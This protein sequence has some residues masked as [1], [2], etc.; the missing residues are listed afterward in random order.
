MVFMHV[1]VFIPEGMS[2]D[3]EGEWGAQGR[4]P[5][6]V[7]S[8]IFPLVHADFLLFFPVSHRPA[9]AWR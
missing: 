6:L 1:S 3:R 8:G 7:I 5:P 4:L 2:T 9:P